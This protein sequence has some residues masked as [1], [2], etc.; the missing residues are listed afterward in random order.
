M[1]NKFEHDEAV[2]SD[3]DPRRTIEEAWEQF[4]KQYQQHKTLILQCHEKRQL[5]HFKGQPAYE[6]MDFEAEISHEAPELASSMATLRRA[7]D[8]LEGWRITWRQPEWRR[9]WEIMDL[10]SETIPGVLESTAVRLPRQYHPDN[11]W[12]K[13]CLVGPD[14]V[15]ITPIGAWIEVASSPATKGMYINLDEMLHIRFTPPE[16]AS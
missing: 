5:A 11:G 1:L 15:G 7:L 10:P 8:A 3:S 6:A 12:V 16:P 13:G 9:E 2:L 14:P 4:F